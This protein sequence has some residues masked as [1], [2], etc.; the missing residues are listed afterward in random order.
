MNGLHDFRTMR[1][2][3]SVKGKAVQVLIDTGSTHNFLDLNTAKG[4]GCILTAISLFPVS[5]AD[6]NKM[7]CQYTCKKLVWK[8]QGVSFDSDMLVL[9][10]GGCSMVFGV[11]WLITLGDIT[12]NFKQLK[13]EFSIMGHKVSLRGIKPPAAKL[14]QQ[15]GMDKLLAKPAELCLISVGMYL[16]E[17]YSGEPGSFFSI[18]TCDEVGKDK[19][20]IQEI[21]QDFNDLF[22]APTELPPSRDHDHRIIL[23]EGTSPIN[24]RPYRYAAIE[25]DEIEKLVNEMMDSGVIRPS[26]SPYSSPIVMFKK[27]DGSWRM[28]VDYRELNSRTIKNKFPIPLIEEL[29]DELHGAKYFSKLDL[30]SGYHQIRMFEPDIPKTVFRTHQVHYEFMV[31]PFG[32]TNAPSTFQSLMNRIF[33]PH[34][35]KFILVFFDDILVYSSKWTDHFSHLRETF[36]IILENV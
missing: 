27:K 21:L 35:R 34:L 29:L 31:M 5:V 16:G 33:L 11:Q 2:T 4:L 24:I 28:C 6:G 13:M 9:P 32:L 22:K 36:K 17:E 14:V 8:M 3:V 7:H 26:T 10:I 30:G 18:N 12:W 1:V 15:S 25:K 23:K 19:A 20:D